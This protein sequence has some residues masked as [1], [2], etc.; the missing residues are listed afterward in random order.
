[1]RKMDD[2]AVAR[3]QQ[4]RVR[5]LARIEIALLREAI[6]PRQPRG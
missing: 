6:D 5:E 3:D 1:M 4:L 2:L